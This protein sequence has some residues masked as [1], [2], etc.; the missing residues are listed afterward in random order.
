MATKRDYY[1]VLGV[2]RT[3]SVTEVRSAYRR[4]AARFHPDVNPGDHT[5]EEKFKELNEA[6]EILSSPD[7][8]QVY[9]QFGHEGPQGGAGGAGFG[10]IFDMFFG[11]GGGFQNSRGPSSS[12][13]A[14]QQATLGADLRYDLEVGM[15]EAAFG[16]D[17]TL[18]LSRLEPCETCRGNGA[19]P[20][21]TPKTCP[22]CS[23]SGQVR[24]VQNT[25]LG[26]FATVAPCTRCKGEGVIIVDPCP[27][28]RG[29]GRMRQTREHTLHVPAGVD[30]GVRLVDAGQGDAG[31][32]GGQRGDLYVVIYVQPHAQFTR[33]GQDVVFEAGITFAQAALGDMLDV[34]ILGGMDK[35]QVPEGTQ[36]GEVFR[37]R[38]KGFPDVNGRGKERGDQ[39]VVVKMQVPTRMTDDQKRLLREF[40][41]ASG[42]KPVH[43]DDRGLFDKVREAWNHK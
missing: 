8:R 28:C 38:G 5:A 16:V 43:G 35:I 22:T 3:A 1:E 13:R 31:V 19:K 15:E 20:G 41:L 12:E 42:E 39:L 21:T 2:E 32:R 26:S 10:D 23:G 18:K 37:L 17:K 14:R 29:Q 36:P 24:H 11:A 6:H 25:I 33:R 34:P 30:T 4:L 7:K 27:T 9:D 40:A